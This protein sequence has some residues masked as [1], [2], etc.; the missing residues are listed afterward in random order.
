[1]YSHRQNRFQGAFDGNKDPNVDIQLNT[2]NTT[3]DLQNYTG[4][5]TNFV[6]LKDATGT[7]V[8]AI[9]HTG[10]M[11]TGTHPLI[12]TAVA[13]NTLSA[14]TTAPTTTGIST[15]AIGNGTIATRTAGEE[16]NV[17]LGVHALGTSNSY[18]NVAIGFEAMKNGYGD[19]NCVAIGLGALKAGEA[20]NNIAI[21][22]DSLLL[23]TSGQ[24]NVAVGKSNGRNLVTGGY[25][26][27]IGTEAGYS[28]TGNR[29]TLLGYQTGYSKTSGDKCIFIGAD[30]EGSTGTV[31]EEVRL[32][33][34]TGILVDGNISTGAIT[35]G[36]STG[37]VTVG[38]SGGLNCGGYQITNVGN[39]DGKDVS[40][41]PNQNTY[42][43]SRYSTVGNLSWNGTTPVQITSIS[44][45]AGTWVIHYDANVYGDGTQSGY[46]Y[47][48]TTSNDE[49]TAV[50]GTC[51][52]SYGDTFHSTSGTAVV[53]PA[54]ATTYYLCGMLNGAGAGV[55]IY[56]HYGAAKTNPDM[57]C[58][59]WGLR[60]A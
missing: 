49:S 31:S 56:N 47:I 5:A 55:M 37:A 41:L 18:G 27:M 26:T 54:S 19:T 20:N 28:I 51:Q 58:S 60:M 38:G 25:N 4:A 17:A 43:Y 29:N 45:A 8:F 30:V 1:M 7:T 52:M 6:N 39:V 11:S 46:T 34:A 59:M 44:L 12:R 57:T 9:D 24:A 32:G 48:C 3:L 14:G 23:D 40:D 33:S 2:G 53:T 50:L 22:S 36:R 21:G 35:L 42:V 13:S 15:I 10:T 16:Y